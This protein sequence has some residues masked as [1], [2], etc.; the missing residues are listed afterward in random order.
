MNR[1]CTICARAGSKGVPNKNLRLL[2]GRPLIAHSVVQARTSG[3]FDHVAVSS[4]SDSILEAAAEAG[5]DILVARPHELASD[6]AAKLPAIRHCVEQAEARLE[7]RFET[8][9]DLDAT[10]PLR[11]VIDIQGVVSLLEEGGAEIV[12]TG[13]PARRSPY[14]NLVEV[15]PDGSV[16]L[17]KPTRGGIFRRQDAPACFDMNASIYAWRR[18][19]FFAVDSVFTPQTRLFVMPDERSLDIDSPLDFE[20]VE[21]LWSRG[22]LNLG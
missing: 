13:T 4:D 8:L 22:G 12:I 17:S 9:V 19:R 10:A 7:R 5:A 11:A 3:L 15:A 6:T 1:L 16:A 2:G 21:F 14:F 20:I 18:D